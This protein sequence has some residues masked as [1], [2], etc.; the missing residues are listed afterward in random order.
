MALIKLML[1]LPLWLF[2]I[3]QL[4]SCDE[5]VKKRKNDSQRQGKSKFAF[6]NILSKCIEA[7]TPFAEYVY[8]VSK[9]LIY[10]SCTIINVIDKLL[11]FLFNQMSNAL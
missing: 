1:I 6:C 4:I 8:N 9:F 10:K 3:F 5:H 11:N 2:A 7:L